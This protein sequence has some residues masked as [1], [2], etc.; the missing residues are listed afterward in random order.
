M[1]PEKRKKVIYII[2][3]IDKAI[4]FEW[5]AEKLDKSRFDLSFI[6]LNN[7]PSYLGNHLREKGIK[8]Q[9]ISVA[10]KSTFPLA[11][12]KLIGLLRKEK[13]D[14]IHTHMYVAD[15]IGQLAG[16]FLGIKTRVY[17]RHSSNENR[18]YHK[19]QRIDNL[20]NSLTTHILAISENV[21]KILVAEENVAEEKIRLIHHGF[22]LE[23]FGNVSH[24][25]IEELSKKYNPQ[26]RKPV[27]GVVARYSHWKGIQ[28]AIG[29]FKKILED[30]PNALLLL[31]NAKRGD[32]KDELAALLTE[33][34]KDSFYEIEFEH[35][36]FALYQLFD[37]Y[38][39]LPIDAELEAFGQ[40][41]VEALAAGI[42]S[43]FTNSGIA[44]E[45]IRNEENALVVG[46]E[47][48]EEVY[49]A[50]LKLLEDKDLR[51]KLSASGKTDVKELFSLEKMIGKLEKLYSE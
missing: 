36:L 23:K 38:T 8:V 9:E 30:Y 11:L 51:E 37:V 21:K 40:T 10:G 39:H 15:I 24:E 42:P 5:I 3:H 18:K 13:P 27:I 16:K 32:F 29:A 41:Y 14:V 35:N 25:E 6:L 20:V 48:S 26:N 45:F 28:Y 50:I 34:P 49:Q 17:T 43:V 4:G 19:K 46:F 33:L 12:L 31:A 7:K 44:R 22:D 2:S 1:P 47:N